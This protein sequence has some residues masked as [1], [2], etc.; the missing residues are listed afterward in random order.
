MKKYLLAILVIVILSAGV[1][2]GLL[3]VQQQQIFKQKASTPT[4]TATVSIL[5]AQANFVRNVDNPV[6]VYFNTKGISVSGVSV[7]LTYSNLGVAASGIQ[8]GSDLLSSGE[9][10]CP[11]KSVT[12]SGSTGQI[13]ISCINTS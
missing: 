7:R 10:T 6:R 1:V 2:V 12:S 9:W 5:P 4:G 3:L 8:I 13:D 11:V